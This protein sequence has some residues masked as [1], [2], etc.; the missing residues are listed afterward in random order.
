[1]LMALTF[2]LSMGRMIS[3]SAQ[4]CKFII[5]ATMVE[6]KQSSSNSKND[7]SLDVRP[8][9]PVQSNGL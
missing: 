4:T 5:W 7:L 3:Q 9:V 2:L 8:L 6:A 1:M